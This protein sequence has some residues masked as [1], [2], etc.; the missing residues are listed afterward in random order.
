MGKILAPN[1]PAN[2][3]I[4]S[5]AFAAPVTAGTFTINGA[6]IT[7][8]ATDTLQD[9]FDHISAATTA[10]G[11]AVTASYDSTTDT[12]S[13]FSSTSDIVLG[14]A[15][16]SSNF[17]Q[18]A[19]LYTNNETNNGTTNSITSSLALGRIQ[20][21]S[22]MASSNLQTAIQDDGTG[23]GALM[24]NGVTINYNASTDSVQNVL[25]RITNSTAGVTA[26]FRVRWQIIVSS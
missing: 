17:L 8:A 19:Q 25:D 1:G 22:N 13:F 12:I 5:A 16:D 6:Q 21:T 10:A 3:T 18:A 2:T 4:G 23:Q 15:T 9:V 24:V 26:S 14:S 20:V 7:V 11:S